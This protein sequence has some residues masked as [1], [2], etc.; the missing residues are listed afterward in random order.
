MKIDVTHQSDTFF[1]EHEE[2]LD[3][4]DTPSGRGQEDT[5]ESVE[6]IAEG[7]LEKNKVFEEESINQNMEEVELFDRNDERGQRRALKEFLKKNRLLSVEKLFAYGLYGQVF[8]IDLE[9]ELPGLEIP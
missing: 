8:I 2:I 7:W 3:R 1:I 4:S 5:E 6:M 9:S